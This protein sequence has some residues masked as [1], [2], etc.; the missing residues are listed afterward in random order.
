MASAVRGEA[1]VDPRISI[2]S[3]RKH[4][5]SV[6]YGN[7]LQLVFLFVRRH[8]DMTREGNSP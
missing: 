4:Q 6:L 3:G 1:G 7:L 5:K 2:H 8:L